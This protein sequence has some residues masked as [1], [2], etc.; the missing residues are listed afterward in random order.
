MHS[1]S[2]FREEWSENKVGRKRVFVCI[3]MK[4]DE[5]IDFEA[6]SKIYSVMQPDNSTVNAARNLKHKDSKWT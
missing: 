5:W 6:V 4:K 2:R 3:I 1:V